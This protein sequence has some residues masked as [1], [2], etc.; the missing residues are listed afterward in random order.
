MARVNYEKQQAIRDLVRE[1]EDRIVVQ[2]NEFYSKTPNGK[3]AEKLKNKAKKLE[4][5]AAELYR[6]AKMY[7][8]GVSVS[9]WN[10]G[11]VNLT[12][13]GADKLERLETLHKE[14]ATNL[15]FAL[16]G[17]EFELIQAFIKAIKSL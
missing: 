1:A 8:P 2:D 14:L 11:D 4:T 15:A 12:K 13:T 9:V 6:Q 3:Q 17:K 16:N 7:A 10:K 5:Q